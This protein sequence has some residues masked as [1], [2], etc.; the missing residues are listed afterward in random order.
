M[1]AHVSRRSFNG[2]SAHA[3]C[4]HAPRHSAHSRCATLLLPA[5]PPHRLHFP[6]AEPDYRSHR[7][8]TAARPLPPMVSS[9]A[10]APRAHDSTPTRRSN[11]SSHRHSPIRDRYHVIESLGRGHM[12]T[13]YRAIDNRDR[14]NVAVKVVKKRLLRHKGERTALF[15]EINVLRNLD[16][17]NILSF[18]H[19]FEDQDAVY[20]ITEFI[21]GGDLYT[22]L[23]NSPA[24]LPERQALRF[25]RQLLKAL[26]YLQT[27][28]ISHRDI[29]PE[30]ILVTE[31]GNIKLADFG[32]CHLR[33]PNGPSATKHL[34]GTP[35]YAA[36]EI[37]S[38]HSYIPEQSD[39]WSCGILFYALLTKSLPY[40]SRDKSSL[41][42]EIRQL[43][44]HELL[45]SR[46][47][48]AVSKPSRTLLKALLSRSPARR[49]SAASAI[50]LVED[51]MLGPREY[52]SR[53]MPW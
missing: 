16:H 14:S 53:H 33:R 23:D 15:R 26:H 43:D 27:K 2:H 10:S 7:S 41:M 32:L 37:A 50:E 30:N 34:C 19:A 39:M 38:N 11:P 21:P 49:P 28:G 18:R 47:L 29:K 9:P 20:I 1:P 35:Q 6:Y 17:P 25:M 3:P 42:R 46:K 40:K 12:G 45:K 4:I 31:D 24:G 52:R 8:S 48:S 44:T 36:P 22:Y 13:V 5:S 51:A